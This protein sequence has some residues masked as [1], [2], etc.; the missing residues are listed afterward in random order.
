[1]YTTKFGDMKK[2]C[3]GWHHDLKKTIFNN[4]KFQ[5]HPIEIFNMMQDKNGV[6]EFDWSMF[7]KR[8][9]PSTFFPSDW[10]R[11]EVVKKILEAR[12]NIEKY[13]IPFEQQ[14][15]G[16]FFAMGYTKE[17]IKVKFV[18]DSKGRI[19]TI[20]PLMKDLK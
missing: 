5:G 20:H 11:Q 3:S 7:G 17:G 13:K 2:G 1:M 8:S 4:K 15:N 10:T 9:K 6:Y 18:K 14:K 19:V 16:N 12:K